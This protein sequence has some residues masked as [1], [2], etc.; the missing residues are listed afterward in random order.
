MFSKR[1][2]TD[3]SVSYTIVAFPFL[4]GRVNRA[5]P[6]S[7]Q[8]LISNYEKN[9]EKEKEMQTT[10]K[11]FIDGNWEQSNKQITWY[12][13]LHNFMSYVLSKKTLWGMSASNSKRSKE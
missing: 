11:F 4:V 8:N 9:K 3:S 2:M 7:I 5:A 13:C 6:P 1:L 12:F 10:T